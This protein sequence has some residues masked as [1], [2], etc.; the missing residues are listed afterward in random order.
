VDGL[1]VSLKRLNLICFIQVVKLMKDGKN[2]PTTAAIGDG[3]ND[4]SMI[5]EADVGLGRPNHWYCR[6]LDSH[7]PSLFRNIFMYGISMSDTHV[8]IVH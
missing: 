2:K 4:V 6:Y 8:S 1:R 7:F 3:A 5:R